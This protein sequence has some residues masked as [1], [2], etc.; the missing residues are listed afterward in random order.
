MTTKKAA[1]GEFKALPAEKANILDASPN[2][3][4]TDILGVGQYL[5]SFER[6]GKGTAIESGV[7]VEITFGELL[8]PATPVHSGSTGKVG[9]STTD[10]NDS[11]LNEKPNVPGPPIS[12]QNQFHEGPTITS[13]EPTVNLV[14]QL[15]FDFSVCNPLP[16]DGAVQLTLDS[17]F[18]SDETL[19]VT[20]SMSGD[21]V[22]YPPVETEKG[23]VLTIQRSG[24]GFDIPSGTKITV[25]IDGVKNPKVESANPGEG[26][27]FG[28]STFT[29]SADADQLLD[30][31]PN[32]S[33]NDTFVGVTL[34][35]S[36]AMCMAEAVEWTPTS[37]ASFASTVGETHG[38]SAAY[39][40]VKSVKATTCIDSASRRRL[41]ALG[42]ERIPAQ[43]DLIVRYGSDYSVNV[44]S[45]LL[46]ALTGP[47]SAPINLQQ[48]AVLTTKTAVSLYWESPAEN[49]DDSTIRTFSL[50]YK[51]AGADEA[52][53]VMATGS[54]QTFAVISNLAK[55]TE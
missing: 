3:P 28:V 4:G 45:R 52:K 18:R 39:V 16:A 31:D 44:P 20:H 11:V 33:L 53:E 5:L 51:R 47:P 36:N 42:V 8:N 25:T 40:E 22:V 21:V 34:K 9:V 15:T 54:S 23:S 55:G 32:V 43:N 26:G 2:V 49:F 50:K 27:T 41:H 17:Q 35:S 14:N 29:K 19:K 24:S 38:A 13:I 6:D 1:V 37:A 46:A 30:S 48:D 10:A 12:C 7:D